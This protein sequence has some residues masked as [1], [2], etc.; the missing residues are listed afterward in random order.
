MA[1]LLVTVSLA[2]CGAV[3]VD[4]ICSRDACRFVVTPLK[5]RPYGAIQIC[6]LLLL[7]LLLVSALLAVGC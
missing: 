7:L 5:L 1:F 3:K 2:A 4:R 6:L